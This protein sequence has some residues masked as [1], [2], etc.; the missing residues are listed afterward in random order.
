VYPGV[1]SVCGMD[2]GPNAFSV[3]W[4]FE[5]NRSAGVSGAFVEKAIKK[6]GVWYA[7]AICEDI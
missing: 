1:V 4:R 5:D 6:G 2:S 3:I 7:G